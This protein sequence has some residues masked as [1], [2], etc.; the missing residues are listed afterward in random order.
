MIPIEITLVTIPALVDQF[1]KAGEDGAT[2][3]ALQAFHYHPTED[4]RRAAALALARH[5]PARLAK[6]KEELR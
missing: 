5:T 6:V 1:R 4:H 3:E 2:R